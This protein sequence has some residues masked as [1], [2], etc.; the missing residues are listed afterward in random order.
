MI[1]R[2]VLIA[3]RGEI[4]L[5]IMRT[6]RKMSVE[7]VA[8][9]SDVEKDDLH[10]RSADA[11]FSLG[12]GTVYDTWLN[13]PLII[14]IALESGA[15]AIHPGY[16][17]LSE[18]TD[19]ARACEQ[20]GILFIGPGSDVIEKMGSKIEASRIAAE[21]GVPL[22]P[23]LEGDPEYLIRN[24]NN[25]GL[26]LLVKAA[27]G[28]GGKGMIRIDEAEMLHQAVY[29]AAEQAKRYFADD[30]VYIEKYVLNPRHIEVQILADAFGNVVHLHERE[31]TLQRNHQKVV[32][33]A[34][35]VSLNE[36][37]RKEL[38]EAAVNLAKTVGY[39]SAGTVEFILD[40][41]GKFY[42]LEMNTRIQVEHP[43]TE[44]I[45][46]TDIV[47][48]QIRIAMGMPLSFDQNNVKVNGHAVEVRL[49]AED[50]SQK[51]LP[52]AGYIHK[53]RIP[54]IQGVRVDTA[55][56][57]QGMVHASFDAMIAKIV[58]HG[59]DRQNAI[60][61]LCNAIS[62]VLVHGITTNLTL[63]SN[64]LNDKQYITNQI[65]THSIADNIADW[66]ERRDDASMRIYVAGLFLWLSR[67]NRLNGSAWRMIA[68]EKVVVN[69][70]E[71]Q[72]IHHPKGDDAIIICNDDHNMILEN[73]Q[74]V[75]DKICFYHNK[76]PLR[77]VFSYSGKDAMFLNQGKHYYAAMP[78]VMILPRLQSDGKM[79]RI[80]DLKSTIFG[81][82]LKVNVKADQP[83]KAGDP[84]LILESMKME[85]TLM[86]MH[87]SV[88]SSVNVKEGDQ[89][90]DGQTL[91]CFAR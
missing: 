13:I 60:S 71:F 9:Y 73:I 52:S 48:E 77:F 7:S 74:I 40:E 37:N 46:G 72:I 5:R 21:A 83:V 81:R 34:P 10:V 42:F 39:K 75:D 30:K 67:Y 78:K 89:V 57:D 1:I 84:L 87:D 58:S 63:L 41:E 31:C 25:L 28:G 38:H 19:F 79:T 49:Y 36:K 32:E 64:I 35:S 56:V 18:N 53:I 12:A 6:L 23:R 2:K 86:A 22:L 76:T 66:T 14:D 85:N 54:E 4:A 15:D 45:T 80:M 61:K 88:V 51:F 17:F 24:G 59:P 26:P 16:G 27:A 43:V 33:E 82:V 47:E 20:A 90:S 29:N 50:P 91:I 70:Q 68:G 11:A 8:L 3:N 44:A 55:I 62:R 69:D 65:S